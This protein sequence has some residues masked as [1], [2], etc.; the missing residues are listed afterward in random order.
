MW[1]Y[2]LENPLLIVEIDT[3]IDWI[4]YMQQVKQYLDGECD[5]TKIK[6]D[7]GPLVYP[8]AHLYIY[9]ALYRITDG[10]KDTLVAQIIFA[11]LYLG[12]LSLV[13]A[14]YTMAKA[15]AYIFP[16][17]ILS[18]RLH[19]IFLLR[20]FNDCFAIG[21]LFLSVYAYQRRI[22]TVGSVTYSWAV[23]TKMSV[24]L[25]APAV[26]S[27]LLLSLPLRRALNAA[28]L[29]VQ[30]Q[31]TIAFPFLPVN[32]YGYIGR[33]FE[34]TRQF[35]FKWTVNWRFVGAETFLSREFSLVLAISNLSILLLFFVTRWIR[36]TGLS[37]PALLSTI[38]KP[39]SSQ[40]QQHMSLRIT[41]S[42]ILTTVLSSLSIGMLC[43]RSL[44]YQFFAYIAWSTPF[45]L[46][47]SGMHPSLIYTIWA[48]QEWAWNV[49]PS[50]KISSVVVVGC[51]S[52][53]VFGIWWG[54]RK[55]FA[56]MSNAVGR[57]AK[58]HRHIE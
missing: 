36:P 44:H 13:M 11:A 54:T 20:L 33:A 58:E 35:L 46:W 23:G 31:F 52:I 49:Y 37:L 57:E 55:D 39:L 24:L 4:A 10:G 12:V 3:E 50:T 26:F 6:G 32:G 34:F 53:Q 21:A 15:P 30:V 51:L 18:K 19:S 27:I 8:A 56:S 42:F 38:F 7:T 48:A 9:S 14:C 25:A 16:L 5:Y 17:L 2:N 28:F 43:A 22:W 47:R 45:L 1:P 41:P 29:M 40:A